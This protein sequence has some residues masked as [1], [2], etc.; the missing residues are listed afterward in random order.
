MNSEGI[1][2]TDDWEARFTGKPRIFPHVQIHLAAPPSGTAGEQKP[3]I[4]PEKK[5]EHELF[6]ATDDEQIKWERASKMKVWLII[7]WILL[8]VFLIL[9]S[10][11]SVLE[12]FGVI[13]PHNS[14]RK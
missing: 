13:P 9:P 3:E 6:E 2:E 7:L 10:L 1:N 5:L 11:C 12:T 8:T 4:D 14:N